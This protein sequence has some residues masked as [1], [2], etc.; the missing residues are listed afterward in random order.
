MLEETRERERE[1]KRGLIKTENE[2]HAVHE[3]C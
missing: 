1:R 3:C 2:S